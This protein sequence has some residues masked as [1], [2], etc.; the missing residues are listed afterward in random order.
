[1]VLASAATHDAFSADDLRFLELI[2]R[3]VGMVAHRSELIQHLREE[4]IERGRRVAGEELITVLAHDI[5]NFLTPLVG[6]LSL[7]HRRASRDG[8]GQDVQDLDI[9]N[10][11]VMRLNK[12][13]GDLLNVA[14]LEGGAFAIRRRPVELVA[15]VEETVSALDAPNR[16]IRIQAPDR[17]EATVDPDSMR[18]VLENLLSNAVRHS[19]DDTPVDVRL[20]A[21]ARDDQTWAI[22]TVSN[23]G[24]GVPPELLPR[25]FTRF[26]ADTS[27][28]G[29]GLGLYIAS[30]IVD[31]HGGAIT[32]K[33]VPGEGAQFEVA[34][35]VAGPSLEAAP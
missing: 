24:P 18:Q 28:M 5:K 14:R 33:S 25:L 22:I 9:A 6:R 10:R 1:V 16:S 27:S 15:L 30:K 35:P 11:S 26:V 21:Q 31:L 13:T 34:V 19:P 12:L 29:V 3:W 23:A 17:L 4:S 32:A 2:G 20:Q 7:L 8:R